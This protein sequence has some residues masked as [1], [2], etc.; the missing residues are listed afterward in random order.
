[1]TRSSRA[2]RVA[3]VLLTSLVASST[4]ACESSSS[5][6]RP[7]PQQPGYY[8]GQYPPGQYPPGQYPPGQ[9]PPQ[10]YP[11]GQQPPPGQVPPGQQPP[12]GQPPAQPPAQPPN[13]ND[14][15]N[16]LNIPWMRQRATGIIGELKA[17]LPADKQQ[18]VNAIP[19]V[20]DD[21]PGEVNAFAACTKGG[22]SLMAITD[23]LLEIEAMLAQAQATD[24]LFGTRKVDE[25]IAFLA[26]NLKPNQPIPRPAVGFFNPVQAA[27][28]R[29][30]ARQHQ[31][32]DE[33]VAFV[34][35]H[36]L[37]HHYLGHLPCT[38]SG[39]VTASE[40]NVVL[41][42]AIPGF[43]QP[44]EIASDVAGIDN[45][46][47]AGARRSDYKWTEGGALLTMRFFSGLSRLTPAVILTGFERSHPPPQIR[48]PIIRQT[49]SN[50]RSSG[51]NPMPFPWPF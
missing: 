18:R 27:D 20:I 9:H 32:F 31:V 4:L 8:G 22:K 35:G 3:V 23:G 43:N 25:Y 37:G 21:T 17:A 12:P 39:N 28:G 2:R 34:L 19:L 16:V 44:N 24:E 36:E 48:E 15:L 38:A 47:D 33:Q 29:K 46:L 10:Q 13:P 26:Q 14:P 50:W 51:G 11:P 7:P 41:S 1:M 30:V 42:S 5:K 40:I 45:V 6:N 49:A